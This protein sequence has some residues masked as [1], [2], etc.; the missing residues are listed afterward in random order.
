[1]GRRIIELHA[2]SIRGNRGPTTIFGQASQTSKTTVVSP[3]FRRITSLGW[4]NDK[5]IR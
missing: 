5:E 2:A 1:V 3:G 4:W